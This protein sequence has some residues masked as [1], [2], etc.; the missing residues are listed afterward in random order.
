MVLGQQKLQTSP[1]NKRKPTSHKTSYCNKSFKNVLTVI[2][3]SRS[4]RKQDIY[5]QIKTHQAWTQ[6]FHWLPF[7]C[8][9]TLTAERKIRFPT[10]N[11]SC[12][13][14]IWNSSKICDFS[15]TTSQRTQM[16][17]KHN[18]AIKFS[19]KNKSTSTHFTK[20]N[21]KPHRPGLAQE[22]LLQPRPFCQFI[23]Q[24]GKCPCHLPHWHPVG[25]FT[26]VSWKGTR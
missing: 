10:D 15:L 20:R 7:T 18:L 25:S 21:K 14:A 23:N 3:W 13:A 9:S 17:V 12:V 19:N 22:G 8:S 11:A 16:W 6:N 24:E 2:L 1:P 5:L 4:K 26:L